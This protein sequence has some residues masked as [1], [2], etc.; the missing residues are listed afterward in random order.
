MI[1]PKYKKLT[2]IYLWYLKKAQKTKK[3]AINPNLLEIKYSKSLKGKT[4]TKD[5]RDSNKK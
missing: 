5:R 1:I 4:Y 2:S 3:L